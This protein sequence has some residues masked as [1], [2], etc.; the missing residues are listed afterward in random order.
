MKAESQNWAETSPKT[1]IKTSNWP[2][3]QSQARKKPKNQ[4]L[5][6]NP[7]NPKKTKTRRRRRPLTMNSRRN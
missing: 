3:K 6:K 1:S 5:L 4:L 2:P 7:K